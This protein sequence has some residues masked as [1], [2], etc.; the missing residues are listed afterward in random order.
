MNMMNPHKESKYAGFIAILLTIIMI[1]GCLTTAC[2]PKSEEL[3]EAIAATAEQTT[4]QNTEEQ[5]YRTQETSPEST[6]TATDTNDESNG[7][8]GEMI[9]VQKTLNGSATNLS[10][11]LDVMT[12]ENMQ[13]GIYETCPV[14]ID[15]NACFEYFFPGYS[16]DSVEHLYDGEIYKKKY[17]LN[18]SDYK[19]S[20]LCFYSRELNKGVGYDINNENALFSYQSGIAEVISEGAGYLLRS[21]QDFIVPDSE[22][23]AEAEEISY[24]FL[25]FV[26]GDSFINNF[27][28]SYS[29]IKKLE[30]PD[31][32]EVVDE[33]YLTTYERYIE[34][35]PILYDQRSVQ[36]GYYT[37][38][39]PDELEVWVDGSEIVFSIGSIRD[40]QLIEKAD[41]ISALEALDILKI[42]FET[43]EEKGQFEISKFELMY[44]PTF[45]DDADTTEIYARKIG[46]AYVKYIPVWV[47]ASGERIREGINS[48]GEY[49]MIINAVTGE[50]I[51]RRKS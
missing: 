48:N 13:F 30:A 23:L 2:Q 36:M 18:N 31:D 5:T 6:D 35:L 9:Y 19:N 46:A 20:I 14:N 22:L 28:Q 40:I 11:N 50:V 38:P 1:I 44:Y 32:M 12:Y 51:Q 41:V 21:N 24:E 15:V 47:I 43:V 39:Y 16:K 34:G 42:Y 27:T 25:S 37:E 45:V 49:V 26:F 33:V 7:T 17:K 29:G 3:S 8:I 4:Q 10:I